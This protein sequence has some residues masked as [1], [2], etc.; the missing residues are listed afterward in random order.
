MADDPAESRTPLTSEE[1]AAASRSGVRKHVLWAA[2]LACG[3]N[4]YDC[5]VVDFSLGGARIH[6]ALPVAKGERVSLMLDQ[7]GTLRAEVIWREEQS[8]GLRFIDDAETIAEMI[9][10]R[11]PLVT[12]KPTARSA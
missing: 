7:L 3:A 6:Q 5:V 8:I 1:Q 4:R 12:T 10:N 9:G 2:T 11:L